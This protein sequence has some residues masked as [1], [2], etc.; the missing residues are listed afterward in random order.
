MSDSLWLHG[1][2]SPWNSPGQNT[3]VRSLSL[4]QWIFLTKESNR[5]LLHCRWILYQLSHEGSPSYTHL[6]KVQN[7]REITFRAISISGA[8]WENILFLSPSSILLLLILLL[9]FC[10]IFQEPSPKCWPLLV[11]HSQPVLYLFSENNS[12]LC[13]QK[14]L[15]LM[16][17]KVLY[18]MWSFKTPGSVQIAISWLSRKKSYDLL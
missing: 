14:Y 9:L 13:F 5:D 16:I 8:A 2:Y 10:P 11:Q 1:L 7:Y 17:L 15:E 6:Y 4:L 3:G 18:E 12:G